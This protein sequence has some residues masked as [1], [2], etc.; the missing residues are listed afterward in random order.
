MPLN[1]PKDAVDPQDV[2]EDVVEEH[3]RHV[4]LFFI[5]DL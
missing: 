4:E 5:E 2:V 3:Q 1:L